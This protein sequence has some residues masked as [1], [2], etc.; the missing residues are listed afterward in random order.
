MEKI[1]MFFFCFHVH[2]KHESA[3]FHVNVLS[4]FTP[5][6]IIIVKGLTIAW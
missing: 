2:F 3:C 4:T 5:H 6:Y 1:C